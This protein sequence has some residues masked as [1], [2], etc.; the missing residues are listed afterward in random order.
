MPD[1]HQSEFNWE[2]PCFGV[3]TPPHL[4]K[5]RLTTHINHITHHSHHSH[6]TSLISPNRSHHSHHT[7]DHITHISH[8]KS[9]TALA[10]PTS[11]AS[12]IKSPVKSH[13]TPHMTSLTSHMSHHI[14]QHHMSLFVAGA[15]V[16][17]VGVALFVGDAPS[18]FVPGAIFGDVGASLFVAGTAF[19][20]IL[21]ASAKCCIFHAKCISKALKVTSAN[22]TA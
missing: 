12:Y 10:S 17:D 1:S 6:L 11:L 13:I 7:S 4:T 14:S 15:M 21:V 22:G 20:E 8:H 9:V 18:L 2:I 5:S 19:G 3:L 16:G